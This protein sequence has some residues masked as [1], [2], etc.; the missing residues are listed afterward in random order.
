MK[1]LLL[2]ITALLA[3]CFSSKTQIK[4]LEKNPNWK[5]YTTVIEKTPYGKDY[6][7]TEYTLKDGQIDT[8]KTFFKEELR[9]TSKYVYDQHANV[10]QMIV[11]DTDKKTKTV[12][13]NPKYNSEGEKI[14]SC[15]TKYSYTP[16]KQI[17]K[18]TSKEFEES[19]GKEGWSVS[20]Q[21]DDKGNIA[22]SEHTNFIKNDRQIDI[23]EFTY[24]SCG[25]VLTI[26]RSSTPERKYPLIGIGGRSLDQHETFEYEYNDDCLWTKK[27]LVKKG[28][29]ILLAEREIK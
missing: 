22:R 17:A 16:N 8:F 19:I 4:E 5:K 23:E 11:T 21:Y 3:I 29:K 9:G 27:Y 7:K 14:E 2:S 6:W 25:N 13:F 26:N 1:N 18:K 20:Y 12:D 10:S 28:K 24:D 15:N